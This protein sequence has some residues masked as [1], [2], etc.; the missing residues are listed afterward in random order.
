MGERA[1]RLAGLGLA[2]VLV[3]MLTAATARSHAAPARPA[4][5]DRS[6]DVYAEPAR[7]VRLRDGRRLNLLC[8]G[9][10]APTVLL[11]S[12]LG[13]S[14]LDWRLVQP[15]IARTTRVCAYDRAGMGFS[16]PAHP[17]RTASAAVTDIEGLLRAADVRAP[18]VL[19]GHSLG[20]F[21]VR[22]FADRHPDLVAGMVLVDPA[23][24]GQAARF[25]AAAKSMGEMARSQSQ[26]TADCAAAAAAGRLALNSATFERCA[27][28]PMRDAAY[29]DA[30]Y[31]ARTRQLLS[32]GY[33]RT[34]D[35]ELGAMDTTSNDEVAAA[36]RSYGDMPLIVL[37]ATDIALPGSMSAND[38]AA[39]ASTWTIM[40]EELARLSSRGI[41]RPIGHA[42]HYIQIDQPQAVVAAIQEVV[43]EA[44]AVNRRHGLTPAALANSSR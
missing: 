27:G 1:G 20:S 8:T 35:S 16:D 31:A 40:H 28:A 7:L 19:V 29:S 2:A 6:L 26:A 21:Y 14:M 18:Y 25:E 32:P 10:G 13:D 3:A 17:P 15:A 12:G 23:K 37:T 39:L 24:E 30:L 5:I 9:R 43:R 4:A 11:E 34:M 42:G 44:R 33:W 22:L 38:K 41:N 36:R